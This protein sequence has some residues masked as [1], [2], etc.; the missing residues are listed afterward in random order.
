MKPEIQLQ[1]IN[2][3]R[4]FYNRFADSFSTTRNQAQP[5]VQAIAERVGKTDSVLDVGCGNGTFADALILHG[6]SGR[7]LG[8]DMSANLISEAKN[9]AANLHNNFTGFQIIDITR[10]TWHQSLNDAPFDWLVSFA[11]LHHLPGQNLRGQVV[12]AF[13]ELVSP[14]S[15]IVVSVWQ[16][17]N[18]PRLRK[19]ILPWSTIGLDPKDLDEGDVLLDWRAEETVGLRYV[20][21]FDQLSLRSLGHQAGFQIKESFYSDGKTGDLALYQVWQLA[22]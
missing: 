18:S 19:R 1:L 10:P 9:R 16:W 17:Q 7:Y 21:T 8:I 4:E 22:A 5:G 6:F 3:N 14:H 12:K 13:S 11:V 15:Q 20:H 2:L